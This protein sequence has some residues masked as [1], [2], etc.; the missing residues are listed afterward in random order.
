MS[1]GIA[2]WS[3][4]CLVFWGIVGVSAMISCLADG[5]FMAALFGPPLALGLYLFTFHVGVL[6][7][8]VL[9]V[10]SDVLEI[11]VRESGH[12]RGKE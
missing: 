1:Y 6:L 12:I 2:V 11:N 8:N 5:E 4:C 10:A 7:L 3:M 9:G